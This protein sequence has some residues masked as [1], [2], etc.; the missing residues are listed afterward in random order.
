ML[1]TMNAGDGTSSGID[2]VRYEVGR[3]RCAVETEIKKES[4]KEKETVE[5]NSA[6]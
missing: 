5:R 4:K 3:S 6:H 1:W 2:T